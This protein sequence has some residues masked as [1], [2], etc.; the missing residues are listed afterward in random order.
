MR[1]AEQYA[2]SKSSV[3]CMLFCSVAQAQQE[4]GDFD[5]A[6]ATV[7][8]YLSVSPGSPLALSLQAQL[9]H[10][11]AA[12]AV[13]EKKLLQGM[14]RNLEHDPRSEA[15]EAAAAEAGTGNSSGLL[16]SVKATLKDWFSGVG[17]KQQPSM[18]CPQYNQTMVQD[19]A[20]VQAAMRAAGMDGKNN[21]NDYSQ[22]AVAEAVASLLGGKDKAGTANMEELK[23][24]TALLNKYQTMH[25]GEASLMDRLRFRLSLTWFGIRHVCASLCCYFCRRRQTQQHAQAEPEWE[26]VQ[27]RASAASRSPA[28]EGKENRGF[29][30]TAQRRQQCRTAAAAAAAG[31]RRRNQQHFAKGTT[32][33]GRVE[34]LG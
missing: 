2:Y 23:R 6:L 13:K 20:A 19:I 30:N 8:R 11:K 31:R 12:H 17:S 3:L 22:D 32:S 15:A 28:P 29:L 27:P 34:D 9:R 21:P 26:D 16:G 4:L 24:L 33:S 5:G 14:F 7:D 1:K 18:D 25:A 10:L